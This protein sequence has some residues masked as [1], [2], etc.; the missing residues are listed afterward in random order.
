[1]KEI[2]ELVSVIKRLRTPDGGCP[3]DLKQ[4]P[5]TLREYII[6]EAYELVEA[7]EKKEKQKIIEES[8]DLLL[9]VL[10]LSQ[11]FSERDDFKLQ[12]VASE[13]KD[14]LIR[15]HPHVFGD[16][17]VDSAEE[18]KAN[19]EKIKKKEKKKES[20]LSDY[21]P[22]M[23]SLQVAKRISEQASSVGFDWN[24]PLK[25]LEKVEEELSELRA[26]I[27]NE[28]DDA[29]FEE[30]GDLLFAVANVARLLKINP[31]TALNN[32]N[33][34]FKKRFRYIENSLRVNK[35]NIEKTPLSELEDLWNEAKKDS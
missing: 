13:L 24:E 28:N 4:T 11:I 12:D 15:R 33:N 35:K 29:S 7:I 30:T 17:K 5:E 1:M 26:E 16:V 8:G 6:E 9:Q 21:P 18:V 19:W 2:D 20:I 34:K 27:I 31:D 10:L 32:A 25:A 22:S 14:K 3:W 23:P